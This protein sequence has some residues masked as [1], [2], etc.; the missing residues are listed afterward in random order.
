MWPR[1]EKM[2]GPNEKCKATPQSDVLRRH[3]P[4]KPAHSLFALLLLL[5]VTALAATKPN[6]LVLLSD[7]QGYADMGFQGSKQVPTP[8]LD[9]LAKSGVR[10]TS[11][12][13]TH[14]FCSPTRAGLMTGRYQQRFGHENNPVYDP[15]DENEGLP[16]TERLLPQYMKDGG[17]TTGWV[18]KWH[19]G[20]SPAHTP[21][22]R[23]FDET[24]GFI[25][26]GHQFQ[27]WVPNERQYTLALTRN[28]L[29]TEV[30]EHLTTTFGNEASAFIKRHTD[31]PWMLYVAFNAPHTPHQPTAEREKQFA[32]ITDPERRKCLAQ[33]SILDDAIGHVTQALAESGQADRTLVFFFTDNGGPIAHAA[34]NT[35][36]RAGKGTVYEGGV[37]VPF[38]VSWPGKLPAGA[39]YD[40]PVSSLDVFATALAQAGVPMP[41]D[42][43]HD[44]VNLV[45]YLTGEDK[46]PPHDR[47]FWRMGGGAAH[48]MRDGN[49]KLVRLKG[50]PAELYDLATDIGETK[51][52]ASAKPEVVA[53]LTAKLDAW[54]SELMAPVFAGSSA[55]NED[56]GP[57][58]ANQ[59]N[60]PKAKKKKADAK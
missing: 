38:V 51:D 45:P 55:K 9:T 58:G 52:L 7:D 20:S 21:W 24:F 13:V 19:L 27:N 34:V 37:R 33:I 39:T 8:H 36:L 22:K 48:A 47:L 46:A 10:C 59:K 17:Y 14:P 11:G 5:P 40:Q 4:M 26:G 1:A 35:P 32:S 57:G 29:D 2:F 28:G 3:F 16:L 42:K 6:I 43:K 12:Y 25:G 15:L 23:G 44:G 49:W 53:A 50:K 41:T 30:P 18:G 31:K 60:N 54:N 56:W